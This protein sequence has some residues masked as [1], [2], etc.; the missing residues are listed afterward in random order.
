MDSES[1]SVVSQLIEL[2]Q[3]QLQ[4]HT[5]STPP[6]ASGAEAAA[7]VGEETT[8]I[9]LLA[10]AVAM[11]SLAGVKC[12]YSDGEMKALKVSLFGTSLAS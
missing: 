3:K 5:H 10:L 6:S 2:A 12:F 7:P 1:P 4:S 8:V 9:E 11:F